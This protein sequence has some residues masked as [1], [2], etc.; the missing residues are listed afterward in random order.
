MVPLRD[1]WREETAAA[2]TDLDRAR[3]RNRWDLVDAAAYN[4]ALGIVHQAVL[5]ATTT[6][7]IELVASARA[8]LAESLHGLDRFLGRVTGAKPVH[9]EARLRRLLDARRTAVESMRRQTAAQLAGAIQDRVQD[10]LAVSVPAGWTAH[11]LVDR[12]G[13][14]LDGVWWMVERAVRTETAY[15]YNAAQADAIGALSADGRF[16][17]LMKRW[18]ERINDGTGR[19]LDE[20]V[21]DDSFVLHGQVAPPSGVFTMPF[22]TRVRDEEEGRTWAFPPNRPNDRAV[23]TPWMRGWGIPGWVWSGSRRVPM[24]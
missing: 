8:T 23:V 20:L 7:G 17:G 4:T 14:E 18:T 24:R 3:R 22:D 10:R 6:V 16:R 15:A 21:G 12:F 5:R 1:V 9:D 2:I 11:Q 19:G 13:D